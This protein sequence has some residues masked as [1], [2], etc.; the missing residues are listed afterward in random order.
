[1]TRTRFGEQAC[2]K[3]LARLD[4][5]IDNELLTESSLELVE[6]FQRCT[7]CTRESQERRNVRARLQTAVREV[8]V[9]PGLED[10]VR[11]RLRQT[12]EPSPKRFHLMAIAALSMGRTGDAPAVR[13]ARAMGVAVRFAAGHAVLLA[14]G[15]GHVLVLPGPPRELATEWGRALELE[16]IVAL[17]ARAGTL[18]RH[19]LRVYGVGEPAEGRALKARKVPAGKRGEGASRATDAECK[20]ITIMITRIYL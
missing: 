3:V 6:H 12:R 11:D 9:P 7:A 20:V 13:R 10:R 1:M 14:L 18:L 8:R 5:Y 4:S 19:T 16:P 2:Q 17:R 15:A